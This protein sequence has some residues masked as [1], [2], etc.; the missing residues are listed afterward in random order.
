MVAGFNVVKLCDGCVPTVRTDILL[1]SDFEV[2]EVEATARANVPNQFCA[3]VIQCEP[4]LITTT[5]IGEFK[6]P[7]GNG[8]SFNNLFVKL[9]WLCIVEFDI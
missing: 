6:V 9:F 7:N 8:L 2:I 1:L 3:V 4:A 5:M